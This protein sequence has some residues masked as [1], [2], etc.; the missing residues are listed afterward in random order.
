MTNL[1]N[2]IKKLSIE[3]IL[4]KIKVWFKWKISAFTKMLL[5]KNTELSYNATQITE[6]VTLLQKT[7]TST[8]ETVIKT[9]PISKKRDY[10]KNR[11]ENTFAKRGYLSQNGTTKAEPKRKITKHRN[12][13]FHHKAIL[14]TLR[15]R[16]ETSSKRILHWRELC[17]LLY[18]VGKK[19]RKST[20]I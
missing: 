6:D 20:S 5:P 19:T 4:S 10:K 12:Q 3:Y 16:Q 2:T 18:A 14:C 7:T 17:W 13:S 11:C 8:P 15:T 1:L 9:A